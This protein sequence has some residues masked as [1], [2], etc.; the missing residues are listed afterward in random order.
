MEHRLDDRLH[1]AHLEVA[2]AEPRDDRDRKERTAQLGRALVAQDLE[3]AG[4]V[5]HIRL[6]N[7]ADRLARLD[8]LCHLAQTVG[9]S[10]VA[11][12]KEDEDDGRL[13]DVLFEVV[14]ALEIVHV[15][16]GL[17]LRDEDL[18]LPLDEGDLVLR[19]VPIV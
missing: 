6:A 11:A 1:R 5:L 16:E 10:K 7:E 12:G 13:V 19:R 15:E 14:D 4:A 9:R 8:G 18:Q 2:H 17:C 3:R